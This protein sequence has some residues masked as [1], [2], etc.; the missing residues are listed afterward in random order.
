MES[1]KGAGPRFIAVDF[2]CGA[3]GTTRGLIDAGGYV[4]AGVD[5]DASCRET[6]EANNR[7]LT[8]DGR[9]A[10]FIRSNVFPRSKSCPE[11]EQAELVALLEAEIARARVMAPGAPLLF[12]ICAPCQPFTRLS[13]ALG[14]E[15][16]AARRRDRNL[17][18]VASEFVARWRPELVL[19]ENVAGI[20]DPKYGGV[21]QAFRVRLGRLGYAAGSRV[22]CTSDFGVPQRRRRSI[23]IAARKGSVLPD[24]VDARG[25]LAVPER[26]PQ[27]RR[28]SVKEA[29]GH[30]PP[31]AAGESHPTIPNHVAS[32][33]SEINLRRIRT[34]RPG[35]SN[36]A[37][38]AEGLGLPCHERGAVKAK[39]PVFTDVYT[40]MAPDA[41]APTI[42][43]NSNRFGNGRFGHFDMGQDRAIT[44]KEA[45]LLQS[46]PEDYVFLPP[47]AITAC[48]RMIGNAVPPKLSEFFAGHLVG[49]LAEPVAEAGPIAA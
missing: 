3:G 36:A 2:F 16:S 7:N 24:A 19:S 42:T 30:L 49:M 41:L 47:S 11:G 43:T 22:V 1:L 29:I 34:V 18:S 9:A 13:H 25:R 38:V 6:Y 45:A 33:L 14:K 35:M 31:L 37:L 32:T 8:L 23:M 20:S 10:R 5:K 48:A 44:L 27:A 26:D 28:I 15:R 46:F 40:R 39:K 4:V 21:W 17:L 12:A